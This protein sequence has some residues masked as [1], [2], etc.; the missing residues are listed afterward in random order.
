MTAQARTHTHDLNGING[1]FYDGKEAGE[2]PVH[3]L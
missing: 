1:E 2:G 3:T